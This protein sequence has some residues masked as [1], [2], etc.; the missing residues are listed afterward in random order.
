MT[1]C[2]RLPA[3]FDVAQKVVSLTRYSY[4]AQE[5]I[6]DFW[7]I[8]HFAFSLLIMSSRQ[9][10]TSLAS[11]ERNR[12]HARK[13]RQR[14]KEHTKILQGRADELKQK[15]LQLRQII[16]E[17]NTASILVGLFS[18]ADAKSNNVEDPKIE[19][20]LRRPVDD[21]PDASK[22]PELP[23]LIL[24]GHHNTKRGRGS[25]CTEA[26][27][28]ETQHSNS[29]P[30]QDHDD[31]PDDGI[32]YDLL[33]K[34]R[35]KCTPQELDQIRR[36]RNRM[37]AKRTRDRKRM[38]IEEMEELIKSLEEENEILQQ[39]L[40]SMDSDKTMSVLTPTAARVSP[41]LRPTTHSACTPPL[42]HL[43][44]AESISQLKS[45][46]DVAVAF[47]NTQSIMGLLSSAAT[48]VSVSADVSGS[49]CCSDQ[50][51]EDS[52]PKK[53]RR[54]DPP[55]INQSASVPSSITTTSSDC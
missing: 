21:I 14:K 32:D 20:L 2:V 51:P 38:F 10:R 53:L 19:A 41:S 6:S 13:T 50:E 27:D 35:S 8:S 40:A 22:I 44:E 29:T 11:R 1:C 5:A 12:M 3:A 37:H 42:S 47:E 49:S 15:Q 54:L 16:N 33:G 9:F 52:R 28:T 7:Y 4:Q 18:L 43:N 23:A 17:K 45:L 55:I 39:H 34:D 26:V 36:E 46:L 30:Q 31:N 24:P 25:T 48:A